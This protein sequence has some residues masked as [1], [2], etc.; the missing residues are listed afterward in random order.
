MPPPPL[1]P[2]SYADETYRCERE[3]YPIE[4]HAA[5]I[6]FSFCTLCPHV[7]GLFTEAQGYN[8]IGSGERKTRVRT[9][10]PRLFYVALYDRTSNP[11]DLS[12]ASSSP[13]RRRRRGY[14]I[15]R[16]QN[17]SDPHETLPKCF[18]TQCRSDL[19]HRIEEK[20]G[21]FGPRTIPTRH[22]STGHRNAVL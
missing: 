5:T 22:S 17:T 8:N 9:N 7:L 18:K 2:V 12:I 20:S 16:H 21:H 4:V 19:R 14:R 1:P 15:L 6:R 10:S 11:R 13:R 3:F